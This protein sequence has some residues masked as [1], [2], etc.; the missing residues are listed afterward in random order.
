MNEEIIQGYKKVKVKR[1]C[2]KSIAQN[3]NLKM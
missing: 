2:Q 3:V 1:Q